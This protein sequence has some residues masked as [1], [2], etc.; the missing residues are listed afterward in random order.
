MKLAA[1][2]SDHAVLQREMPVP[3]WGTADPGAKVTVTFGG[4][5]KTVAA[6]KDGGWRL[7]LEPLKVGGA[8]A[9]TIGAEGEKAITI[10]DV[11]VGEVWLCGGQSNMAWME[12]SRSRCAVSRVGLSHSSTATRSN[13]ASRAA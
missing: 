9:M 1:I 2:F 13:P 7:K 10:N 4:Q 3:V 12:L 5:T 8:G 6:G 11:L